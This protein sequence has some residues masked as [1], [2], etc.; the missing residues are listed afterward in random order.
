MNID[1][2]LI[3]KL[4]RLS[5]LRYQSEAE[6]EEI[7]SDLT[8]MLSF[9][10]KVNELD[11]SDTEPLIHLINEVNVFR[12]D[13]VIKLNNQTDALKN[14]PVNDGTYIKVPKVIEK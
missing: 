10:E 11:T 3:Q 7:K 6:I 5:K 14:A 2:Q 1:N 8:Q 12:K 9:V 13:E 4:A